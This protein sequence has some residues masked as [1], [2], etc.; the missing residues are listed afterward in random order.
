MK[1][2][3]ILLYMCILSVFLV[4]CSSNSKKQE[5]ISYRT[6]PNT[7]EHSSGIS[8]PPTS[9]EDASS[10]ISNAPAPTENETKTDDWAYLNN[11]EGIVSDYTT[12]VC[13]NLGIN[14]KINSPICLICPDPMND[15]IYYVNYGNDNYIYQLKDGKSTL[16]LDKKANFLQ[17][18]NNEIYFLN[19]N[20]ENDNTNNF[21]YPQ[22]IYKYNLETKE[23]ML[24]LDTNATWLYVNSNGIFYVTSEKTALGNDRYSV[25]SNEYQ[26]A[27]NSDSPQKADI[28]FPPYKEYIIKYGTTGG[29]VLQ[30]TVTEEEIMIIPPSI[31]NNMASIYGDNL[32]YKNHGK[33]YSLNLSTGKKIIID[34][35]NS[36]G[37]YKYRYEEPQIS[38][39]TEL[40]GELFIAV[41]GSIIL[42]VDMNSGNITEVPI[43]SYGFSDLFTSG[44]RLFAVADVIDDEGQIELVELVVT[45]D[46]ITVKELTE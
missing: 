30:S 25:L 35:E 14:F 18:W 38:G 11:F 40:N 44:D 45:S 37:E 6:F 16:I 24:V 15:V 5:E 26:L 8:N 2:K 41:Y 36:K 17:L 32:Y 7:E 27:L 43:D 9:M 34:L 1:K 29:L 13:G 39:Y 12:P 46:T 23:L 28:F 42:R 19:D 4:A 31:V 22:S 3:I 33:L 10:S 21:S 20:T